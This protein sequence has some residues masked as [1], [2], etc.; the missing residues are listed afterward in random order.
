MKI[1]DEMRDIWVDVPEFVVV[2]SAH[3]FTPDPIGAPPI[4]TA[5]ETDAERCH[6]IWKQERIGKLLEELEALGWEP[7]EC[8]YDRDWRDD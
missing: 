8:D 4:F 7:P 5:P 2:V 6:R 1:Y 3:S